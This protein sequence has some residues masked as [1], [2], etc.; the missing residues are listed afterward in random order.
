M[1]V[2]LNLI[3]TILLLKINEDGVIMEWL[4]YRD[5]KIELFKGNGDWMKLTQSTLDGITPEPPQPQSIPFTQY[6]MATRNQAISR[7][8]KQLHEH[9]ERENKG[10]NASLY[11]FVNRRDWDKFK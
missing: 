5:D 10:K 6:V 4:R 3:G 2:K 11:G 7:G 8:M 9:R 1:N